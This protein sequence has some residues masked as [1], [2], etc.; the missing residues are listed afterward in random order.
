MGNNLHRN[1]L[2]EA[3]LLKTKAKSHSLSQKKSP[4]C[5]P[6]WLFGRERA[7][8]RRRSEKPTPLHASWVWRSDCAYPLTQHSQRLGKRRGKYWISSSP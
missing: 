3:L 2:P 6:G 8:E 5:Q 7:L 1:S 4:L